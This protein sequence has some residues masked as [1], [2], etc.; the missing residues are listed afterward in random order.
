MYKLK[1]YD[2]DEIEGFFYK[3]ELQLAYIGDDTIYKI[4][5]VLKNRKRDKKTEVL[6]KWK[7][8]PEKCNSW[9][10]KKELKNI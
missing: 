8:W 3:P 7:G 5:K 1:D 2:N 4:A 9:I 10:D 6:L